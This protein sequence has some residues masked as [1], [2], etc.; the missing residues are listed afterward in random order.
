MRIGFGWDLHRLE[1]GRPFVLGG[2]AIP[3]HRGPAGHSDGDVLLHALT[4]ALLGAIAH[5]DIGTH[6]S[7]KDPRW[8]DADSSLFLEEALRWIRE[9]GFSLVNIDITVIVETPKIGPHRDS[10]LRNLSGL[11]DLPT[12]RIGLKAKTHEGIGPIG[13]GDAIACHAAVLLEEM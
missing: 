7:D 6:F 13:E 4:D 3:H 8:K 11:L 10:I 9:R 1:E 5:G 2:L 12:N